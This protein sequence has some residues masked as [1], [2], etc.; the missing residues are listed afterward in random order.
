MKDRKITNVT[1]VTKPLT[2][3]QISQNILTLF[4]K[5][6]KV[7]NVTY[8]SKVLGITWISKDTL[9]VVFIKVIK[10]HKFDMCV[11]V[12]KHLVTQGNLRDIH[13]IVVHNT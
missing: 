6:I 7:T 1:Y 13:I 2:K 12:G 10:N 11:N 8:V 4:M 3:L 9:T 5:D